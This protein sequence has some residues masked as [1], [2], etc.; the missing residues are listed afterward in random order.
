VI[1]EEAVEAAGEVFGHITGTRSPQAAEAIL[2]A[3][4]PFL[5]RQAWDEGNDAHEASPLNRNP[6]R[7]PNSAD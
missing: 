6:Y 1:P 2:K 4:A 5:M 7:K 3:A